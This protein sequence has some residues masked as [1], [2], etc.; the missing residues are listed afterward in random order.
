MQKSAE[1]GS[2]LAAA[3][4]DSAGAIRHLLQMNSKA[5]H[6]ISDDR[7]GLEK[8]NSP[9]PGSI[10]RPPAGGAAAAGGASGAG[11][12]GRLRPGASAGAVPLFWAAREGHAETVQLLLASRATIN[13]KAHN[14]LGPRCRDAAAATCSLP[15]SPPRL[16]AVGCG[17]NDG[18][19][20]GGETPGGCRGL[21][22][23]DVSCSSVHHVV[24]LMSCTSLLP[25]GSQS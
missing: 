13:V 18:P 14:G 2:I 19:L 6:E 21:D 17:E 10:R 24:L 15:V 22:A 5:V 25:K 12:Q 4:S 11:C 3:E 8:R 9:P 1:G 23:V 7:Q 16:H 20:E